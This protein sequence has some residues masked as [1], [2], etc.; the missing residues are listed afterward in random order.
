M[1][2]KASDDFPDPLTPVVMMR[3]P[4]GRD[5]SIFLRLCV[6]A[7]RM[8]ISARSASTAGV[9]TAELVSDIARLDSLSG[10]LRR[11]PQPFIVARVKIFRSVSISSARG[12]ADTFTGSVMRTTL[13]SSEAGTPVKVYRVAFEPGAR[14]HWH[15]HDGPQWL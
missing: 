1:V 10:Q 2:S 13:A 6:R 12:D 15:T 8:T 4:T 7:P 11:G 3:A 9:T 14:T 5:T